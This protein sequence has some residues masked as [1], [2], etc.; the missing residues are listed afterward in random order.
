MLSESLLAVIAQK[1]LQNKNKNGRV[2]ACE[3]MIANSAVRNLI[4]EDKIYQIPSI[5]QSGGQEGMQSLDQDLQR[6]VSQGLVNKKEA[7]YV[8]ENP[9]IFE[10]A[11]F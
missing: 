8:A 4:R 10:K 1:L 3:I 11:I 6:L 5:I 7:K 2:P 9:E